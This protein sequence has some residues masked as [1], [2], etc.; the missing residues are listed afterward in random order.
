VA[1]IFMALACRWRSRPQ[2]HNQTR[3]VQQKPGAVNVRIVQPVLEAE[4]V[5]SFWQFAELHMVHDRNFREV[6]MT[7][8]REVQDLNT[9]TS[10]LAAQAEAAN[11]AAAGEETSRSVGIAIASDQRV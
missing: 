5:A 7:L 9:T 1:P 11:A 3:A 4:R 6:V 8:A 2:H 10:V